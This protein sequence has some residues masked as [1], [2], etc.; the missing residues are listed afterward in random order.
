MDYNA[1]QIPEYLSII[2]NPMDIGTIKKN[3]K[4]SLYLTLGEV[5]EQIQLIWDN[6]KTFNDP[7][8]V[9]TS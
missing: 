1:L 8:T 9:R 2:K 5:L 7:L 6:C 3:L 4:A